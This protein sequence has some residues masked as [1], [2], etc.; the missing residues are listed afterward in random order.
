MNKLQERRTALG[1][2]QPQ[3][4]EILKAADPRI[5]VGM[6]SRFERGACLPTARVLEALETALQA[7]RSVLFDK[8]DLS[9]IEESD[10]QAAQFSE[11]TECLLVHIPKGRSNAIS[12]QRLAQEFGMGDRALRKAIE[13]ARAE[14]AIII[15]ESNGRGY[16]QSEDL[17]EIYTQYRQ[18]TSRALAIL[19]RRKAMRR[20]LKDAGRHV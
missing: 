1:L 6:V 14:G 7:H 11:I 16:Y 12:R 3:L 8:G 10:E 5:D 18:D 13:Q 17:D 9:V 4:S 2:T 20:L 15:N 19:K